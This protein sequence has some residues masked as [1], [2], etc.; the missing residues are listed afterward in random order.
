MI[1]YDRKTFAK[2]VTVPGASDNYM[3]GTDVKILDLG[4]S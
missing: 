3:F 4:Y 2:L 1:L